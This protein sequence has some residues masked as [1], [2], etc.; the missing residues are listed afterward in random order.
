MTS[1]NKQGYSNNV[2][3]KNNNKN[4]VNKLGLSCTKLHSKSVSYL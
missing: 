4:N 3:Y 2:N 1:S